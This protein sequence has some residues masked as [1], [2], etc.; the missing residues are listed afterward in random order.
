MAKLLNDGRSPEE[1]L[2]HVQEAQLERILANPINPGVV[3]VLDEARQRGILTAVGSSSPCDW[4]KGH[5]ER[6]SLFERFETVVTY[7]DVNEP[8]PS[9][10]IFEL[11]LKR[12]DVKPDDALVLE[13][14]ANGVLAASRANIRVVAVPNSVT[15]VMDFSLANEVLGSLL[16]LD[17]NRYF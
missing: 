17:L 14:S 1:L 12:L 7:D 2:L 6:L 11:V 3:E 5:L 4:V 10:E 16:E 8:K 15:E 13:D 9:P